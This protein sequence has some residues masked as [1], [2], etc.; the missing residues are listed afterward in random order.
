MGGAIFRVALEDLLKMGS[1][2]I[3]LVLVEGV[4]RV[5]EPPG[6]VQERSVGSAA[7]FFLGGE[8]AVQFEGDQAVARAMG[9][10]LAEDDPHR[11]QGLRSLALVLEADGEPEVAGDGAGVQIQQAAA[12]VSRLEPT[13][14]LAKEL[15]GLGQVRAGRQGI[16]Q[17]WD[18]G[19]RIERL[20][21]PETEQVQAAIA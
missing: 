14:L 12:T 6:N 16:N 20:H 18:H 4:R 13:S 21:A 1:G 9:D 10:F 15:C 7:G 8:Q 2:A 19:F 3:E 17:G 11:S 5:M